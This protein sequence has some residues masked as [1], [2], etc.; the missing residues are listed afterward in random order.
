MWLSPDEQMRFLQGIS[1]SIM[2]VI[3]GEEMSTLNRGVN[4][5]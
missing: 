4:A 1:G 5:P 3:C 2:T